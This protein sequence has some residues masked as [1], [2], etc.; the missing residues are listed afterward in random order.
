MRIKV[1]LRM[2]WQDDR[3][4]WNKDEFG[5]VDQ[6]HV[7]AQ[8]IFES[9]N[10]GIWLPDIIPYN[11]GE[12]IASTLEPSLAIVYS[13]GRVFWSR[14]GML[15]V[16]C[17]FRGINLFPYD[18]VHC[19]INVGGWAYSGWQQGIQLMESLDHV[20]YS[21]GQSAFAEAPPGSVNVE[22]SANNTYF[23]WKIVDMTAS[24]EN[25]TFPNFPSEPWPVVLY[26]VVLDRD[27]NFFYFNIF[28]FPSL[29]AA[30]GSLICFFLSPD[31]GERLSYCITLN[32]ALQFSKVIMMEMLPICS[33]ALWA[34]YFLLY[35]EIFTLFALFETAVILS[36]HHADGRGTGLPV[37]LQGICKRNMRRVPRSLIW[38]L[39]ST[40]LGTDEQADESLSA[41]SALYHSLRRNRG[42]ESSYQSGWGK[43]DDPG[44]SDPGSGEARS[45]VTT[46]DA[47]ASLEA[48][49]SSGPSAPKSLAAHAMRGVVFSREDSIKLTFFERLFFILD[50]A[51][52]GDGWVNATEVD[53]F[54]SFV[55][56]DLDAMERKRQI[57]WCQDAEDHQ[58]LSSGG[59]VEDLLIA[60]ISR[61]EFI[62]LCI[63]T[64][65]DRDQQSIRMAAETF[66]T[67]Q[68][69]HTKRTSTFWV[70]IASRCDVF[71]GR[72]IV[73]SYFIGLIILFQSHILF[74][75]RI[76]GEK[77]SWNLFI[78]DNGL[79][80]SLI[81]PCIILLYLC[82]HKIFD[83]RERRIQAQSDLDSFSSAWHRERTNRERTNRERAASP[84]AAAAEMLRA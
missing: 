39:P 35:N 26:D 76:Q 74:D 45:S 18:K 27:A 30:I 73:A 21:F 79:F 20:G 58:H 67:A 75:D 12:G 83:R 68:K 11:V 28:I 1:W 8:G 15:D 4:I 13:T 72:F 65:W 5:G 31:V 46:K 56:Y 61:V 41:L 24:V 29:V 23:E 63:H 54:L 6:L 40:M 50:D 9:D 53:T 48:A 19:P 70:S 36:M 59:A 44:S 22:S 32:L 52:G 66:G 77:T 25:R 14:P 78:E 3:L 7:R 62:R 47:P 71:C 55:A 57:I 37:W 80:Y 10:T 51:N 69:L 16:L 38:C 17:R 49:I 82:V 43:S 81:L 84:S 60:R 34:N 64:L 2:A 33:E 42:D